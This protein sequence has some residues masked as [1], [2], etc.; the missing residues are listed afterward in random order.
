MLLPKIKRWV[1]IYKDVAGF[2]GVDNPSAGLATMD[3][4]SSL[5]EPLRFLHPDCKA[6][7]AKHGT[8]PPPLLPF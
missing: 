4:S 3:N 2:V 5:P 6:Y 8:T 7:A 1:S